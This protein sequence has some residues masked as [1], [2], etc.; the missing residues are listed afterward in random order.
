[1]VLIVAIFGS[2]IK[3][4]KSRWD[5]VNGEILMRVVCNVCNRKSGGSSNVSAAFKGQVY[6]HSV[7]PIDRTIPPK[8]TAFSISQ[9]S[10]KHLPFEACGITNSHGSLLSRRR[11][12]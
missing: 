3:D 11:Y 8:D 6:N 5:A 10:Q 2:D 4:V 7:I 12:A 1:M 9:S